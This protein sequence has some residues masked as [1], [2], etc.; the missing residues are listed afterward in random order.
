MAP[1]TQ[2]SP[3][4]P[5]VDRNDEPLLVMRGITKRFPGVLALADVSFDVHPGE[6][7]ASGGRERRRQIHAHEDSLRRLH[8][9]DGG[10]IIFKGAARTF[11]ARRARRRSPAS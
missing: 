2:T 4:N 3:A 10:E 1:D 8:E 11:R 5:V 9:R 7:H 6:V